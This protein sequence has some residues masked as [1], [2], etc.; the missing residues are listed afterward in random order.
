MLAVLRQ[1]LD[2]L[3]NQRDPLTMAAPTGLRWQPTVWGLSWPGAGVCFGRVK[4]TVAPSVGSVERR[5]LC[6][7]RSQW[8]LHECPHDLFSITSLWWFPPLPPPQKKIKERSK[9]WA[10][11]RGFPTLPG[12]VP[13]VAVWMDMLWS[14]CCRWS[15][16]PAVQAFAGGTESSLHALSIL[17]NHAWQLSTE[18]PPPSHRS[19]SR[20][21]PDRD[22]W[23]QTDTVW[24][25]ERNIYRHNRKAKWQGI[26]CYCVTE[27]P[28]LKTRSHILLE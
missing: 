5:K 4:A 13:A 26:A 24:A 1:G 17:M 14:V 3:M 25:G 11:A 12:R 7:H 15:Q 20:S 2:Q 28:G 19:L 22:K 8:F 21:L 10:A 16:A 6:H 9:P 23:G 18:D 27:D